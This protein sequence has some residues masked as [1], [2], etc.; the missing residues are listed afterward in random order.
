MVDKLGRPHWLT[1]VANLVAGA[2]TTLD[3]IIA[4]WRE[5]GEVPKELRATI[6]LVMA[7]SSSLQ[8]ALAFISDAMV[9][10]N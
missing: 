4:S 5:R 10:A 6:D 7:S 8:A 9:E 3:V 1:H 2:H